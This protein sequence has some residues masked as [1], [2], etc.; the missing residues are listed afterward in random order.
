ME[1][2]HARSD[3]GAA[4][5]VSV[6]L[7]TFDRPTLL[8]RAIASI[9][10]QAFGDWELVAIADGPPS[11]ETV[12]LLDAFARRDARIRWV[13]LRDN[14]N[15]PAM[16]MNQAM[17][18][19]RAPRFAFQDDDDLWYPDALAALV[20]GLDAHPDHAM[21]YGGAHV[22]DARTGE[23]V[24]PAFALEPE[25]LSQRNVCA[26]NAVLVERHAIDAVGGYDESDALRA[27]F[28]WDL[29]RR[30]AD[31]FPIRRI[32]AVLGEVWA[33]QP[34]SVGD[35]AAIDPAAMAARVRASRPLALVGFWSRPRHVVFVTQGH[36]ASLAWWRV[37]TIVAAIARRGGPWSAARVDV[38]DEDVDSVLSRADLVVLYRAHRP[39]RV[40]AT[41]RVLFDLDDPVFA[42][43]IPAHLRR[44]HAVTVSTPAL[45][46]HVERGNV[47]VRPN[48]V[49][50]SLLGSTPRRPQR[51]AFAWLAG[52]NPNDDEPFVVDVARRVAR[53][54]PGV[55]FHYRGKSADL[56][57]ALR[58]I[59]GLEV[60]RDDYADVPDLAHYFTE[61]AGRGLAC[62]I[63]PH[64]PDALNRA[65][66]VTKCLEAAILG[67][68]IV[69][70]PVGAY[71]SWITH[72]RNGLLAG[73]ADSMARA[74]VE[75]AERPRFAA[76]LA[77]RLRR[78]V[79]ARRS[80]DR[81]TDRFL[82]TLALAHGRL[83]VDPGGRDPRA[84]SGPPVLSIVIA[85]YETGDLL[86]AC[87]QSIRECPFRD[88]TEVIVVDNGSRDRSVPQVA[89]AFPEV[90]W[91]RNDTNRGYAIANNQGIDAARGRFVLLLNADC[92]VTPGA[93]DALVDALEAT[94]GAGAI[95]ARF[96][97]P[98]GRDQPN[99]MRLPTRLTALVDD[100]WLR[101]VP[102][103]RGHHRRYRMRDFDHRT[104]REVEQVPGACLLI[105]RPVL[106]AVGAFDPALFLYF[107]DVDLCRRIRAAGHTVHFHAAAEIVHHDGA[108]VRHYPKQ[109]AEW[110]R[111]RAHYY[112]K[113][114]GRSG[115]AL[116]LAATTWIGAREVAR[117]LVA[118]GRSGRW[119]AARA[120]VR[121]VARAFSG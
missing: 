77:R 81:V 5:A 60:V 84:A 65:K 86:L 23:R 103:M 16:R 24:H 19:A 69:A 58:G 71:A 106:A 7:T 2:T 76:R 17:A 15:N 54:R 96:R 18:L 116:A 74:V 43:A 49:P 47:H 21:V 94:P 120:V 87:L 73:D 82:L 66:D 121:D 41:A 55:A 115:R 98:D 111:N 12:R 64:R 105:P 10:A 75:L 28:D 44:A 20:A 110:H 14:A 83:G 40:P 117:A 62:V 30:I 9:R 72:R 25:A 52:V 99:C 102:P 33:H 31:R 35:H 1:S 48:G 67:I 59:A 70:S 95:T 27:F 4:P 108:S 101:H 109:A 78:D 114:F 112:G 51:F 97:Y 79:I 89:R 13:H 46:D 93:L 37:D 61:L 113:H 42:D 22:H 57:A 38:D 88:A 39:V 34:D 91:I 100:T 80:I 3:A 104:S 36:P 26:N 50:R 11:R 85:H 53:L 90:A 8:R 32:D 118:P 63:V 68:P 92:E 107:N 56:E 29:W 119:R 45:R 6:I